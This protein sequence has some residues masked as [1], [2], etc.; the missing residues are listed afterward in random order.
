VTG[1][2]GG[3]ISDLSWFLSYSAGM[4]VSNQIAGFSLMFAGLA[5]SKK[6]FKI[7]I[8]GLMS[9]AI[10]PTLSQA[11]QFNFDFNVVENIIPGTERKLFA[12][13]VKSTSK[14]TISVYSMIYI[15]LCLPL[16][17]MVTLYYMKRYLHA[18]KVLK[19][20]EV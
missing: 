10:I 17:I 7:S 20:I 2:E 13:T 4:M 5:L 15:L 18:T 9:A 19:D 16:V 6:L 8:N 3:G 11:S 14:L 12:F 1:T